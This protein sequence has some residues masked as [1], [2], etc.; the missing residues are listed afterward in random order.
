MYKNITAVKTQ[1]LFYSLAFMYIARL[2]CLEL[3]TSTWEFSVRIELEISIFRESLPEAVTRR[4]NWIKHNAVVENLDVSWKR[5]AVS[6]F[7]T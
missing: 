4:A 1:Q 7:S 3:Q 5:F 6:I 2:I